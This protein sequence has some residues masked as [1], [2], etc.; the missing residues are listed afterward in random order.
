MTASF[1]AERVLAGL[2]DFQRATVDHAVDRLY[3]AADSS[4]RFL[5]ADEVGLGKTLVARGVA[6]RTIERLQR[7][8]VERVD[9]VYVCSNA[10]IAAQNVRKL[11]VTGTGA[12]IASR[13]TLL[14]KQVKD[15]R[16]Q[17][18]NIVALTPGTSFE[19][20][21]ATGT[22]EERV[23]LY[24]LLRRAWSLGGGTGPLNVLQ[25]TTRTAAKFRRAVADFDPR[26]IDA[27]I[28]E[29]FANALA[30]RELAERTAGHETI[31]ERFERSSHEFARVRKHIPQEQ[32]ARRNALIG[33]LRGLLAAACVQALEPDLVIL[34]EFQRFKHLLAAD[35]DSEA[36]SLAKSLFNWSRPGTDEHARVLMLSAT[37]YRSLTVAGD[38]G[39]DDH[40]AD[41]LATVSFLA[42]GGDASSSLRGLLAS[43]QRELYAAEPESSERLRTVGGQIEALLSRYMSRTERLGAAGQHDAML[44]QVVRTPPLRMTDVKQYLLIQ[45]IADILEQPD[46]T[47]LWKSAPYLLNFLDGYKLR[48]RFDADRAIPDYEEEL[49]SALDGHADQL[50]D[51]SKL[52]RYDDIDPGAP[53]LR[54][55]V[56]DLID[57]EAWRLLW[58]PPALPYHELGGAYARPELEGFTKRLVFSAWRAV[59]RSVAGLLSYL[60]ERRFTLEADA[61][62]VNTPQRRAAQRNRLN[63]AIDQRGRLTGMPA[64]AILYPSTALALAADPREFAREHSDRPM[65][66]LLSWAASR[67]TPLLERLP[68][69]P[70]DGDGDGDE[71]WYWAAPLMLD[72]RSS[73]EFWALPDLAAAWTD[74]DSRAAADGSRWQD[75][76]DLA[77]EAAGGTLTPPLGV[78]PSDL[79]DVLA[80][81]ALGA[82]G[83]LGVRALAR[84][85]GLDY[86]DL[87]LRI[88]AGQ[89]A[90]GLRSLFNSPEATALLR[91]ARTETFWREVLRHSID[92]G[93]Q[94]VLDEHA[95]IL[96]EAEGLADKPPAKAA[97][98]IAD[99]M[100]RAL[101][102]RASRVTY[103]SVSTASGQIETS[104]ERLYTAYAMR[105]G[106]DESG[107]RATGEQ[108]ARRS[109]L[110]EAFNS[111]FW[112]FALVSTAVG[113]EGLDFHPYC[114]IVV[115]WNLP[116]NPVDLEQREGR[117][118]RYKGH[119]IRKN[120]ARSHG[121]GALASRAADPWGEAF[122]LATGD[123][124]PS[125]SE[126]VPFWIYPLDH[127]AVV[128]RHVLALPLSRELDRLDALRNAL[129]V[130]R[131]AFGQARQ[132]DVIDH[133]LRRFGPDRA[134]A[135]A[136]ELRIDLRPPLTRRST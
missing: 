25:A 101:G 86:D 23:L 132:E 50:L 6:A 71:R 110:R 39:G 20:A 130:Y 26:E 49:A 37:P 19:Q 104:T 45:T 47:E 30:T 106:D 66:E 82:P 112:P 64:L 40:H 113:Q 5:V 119:A 61:T 17:R 36:A 97:Q 33:E 98:V 77:A 12:T 55:L 133:L 52:A 109:Q 124:L 89:V 127:G 3:E 10:E 135:L 28:A 125:D 34:D 43:Y 27:G 131:L 18:L 14:A 107:E 84:V 76:V 88:S 67:I 99:A 95:H 129:A 126:L 136:A 92:G 103:S 16:Q 121:E 58:I 105:F 69:P 85:T 51:R 81:M 94:A 54:A 65:T 118:H 35:N 48:A 24:S 32:R 63:F 53:R 4:R 41:F 122:T 68:G 2:K 56:E 120:V 79:A 111:P 11:D 9:I 59:P 73:D 96:F 75:H 128:E 87:G 8:G 93:L 15:L 44:H 80:L 116:T 13:L 100:A 57:T 72:A 70:P 31:R 62:A 134:R 74:W 117:V 60:A 102:L 108:P 91:A 38:G 114:H 78:K 115:H 1:A 90:W 42:N 29:Q 83:V 123:R 46:V 21:S 22:Q 7:D